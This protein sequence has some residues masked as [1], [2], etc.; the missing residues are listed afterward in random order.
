MFSLLTNL[1]T[2]PY[3]IS[4]ECRLIK[5]IKDNLNDPKNFYN[6]ETKI[7]AIKMAITELNLELAKL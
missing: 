6:K 5:S 3:S 1:F 7:K 4:P 2:D